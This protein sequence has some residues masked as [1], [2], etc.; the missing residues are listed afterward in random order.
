METTVV[1][2]CWGSRLA[3]TQQYWHVVP[4]AG[5]NAMIFYNNVMVHK[6]ALLS[7][8]AGIQAEPHLQN[9][10]TPYSFSR[11][12]DEK[13]MVFEQIRR[14][15]FSSKP[16]RLKSLY[17]F[18]NYTLVER[19]LA[20]WFPNERKN[21]HECRIL[22]DGNCNVHKADTV[23]LNSQPTDWE[24]CARNYWEGNLSDNPFPEIIVDGAIYF[25]AYET[26]PS[27]ASFIRHSK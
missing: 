9:A 19:A 20:E 22:I 27:P 5:V 8:S 10:H 12:N 18:D 1:D 26:I 14:T 6:G 3:A 11:L 17:L 7:V 15:E 23:W 24:R 16:P 4:T 2:T 21:V 25:P 13:E